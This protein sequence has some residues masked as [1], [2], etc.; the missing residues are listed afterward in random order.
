MGIGLITQQVILTTGE[1]SPY[2]NWRTGHRNSFIH[3]SEDCVCMLASSGLWE[4]LS[5]SS[6]YAYICEYRNIRMCPAS[7]H[8]AERT[9]PENILGQYGDS[10]YELI[11]G[12]QVTWT[13][14]EGTC[15]RNGG[16]LAHIRNV[17][18]QNYIVDFLKRHSSNLATW[19]G[20]TDSYSEGNF[21]WTS[22]EPVT[23]TNWMPGYNGTHHSAED[24]V[25]L[26][27]NNTGKWDE[28]YCGSHG[29]I[30]SSRTERHQQLCQ[31]TVSK[32]DYDCLCSTAVERKVYSAPSDTSS[33]V[34]YMY[35]FDCK[36]T[37]T[38]NAPV[39]GWV[40]VAF[41]HQVGY[42]KEDTETSVQ[43][44]N[45]DPPAADIVATA[46]AIIATDDVTTEMMT[47]E[48]ATFPT[49]T[50]P[51]TVPTTQQPTPDSTSTSA[52]IRTTASI[53]LST[54]IE[55][56]T[57]VNPVATTV[58]TAVQSCPLAVQ[59]EA[60]AN[61][62]L[63][64][65]NNVE[66][67]CYEFVQTKHTWSTSESNCNRNGGHLVTVRTENE[68]KELYEYVKAYGGSVWLGL[69]DKQNENNFTWVSG[70]ANSYTNWRPGHHNIF[71]HGSE[72][73]VC[74]LSISGQW[75]DLNC[76]SIYASIC[77][78][79]SVPDN[80][81]QGLGNPSLNSDGNIHMCPT[82]AIMDERLHPENILGQYG[83]SCY[84]LINGSRVT[85]AS[86]ESTCKRNGGHLAHIRNV[87]EQNYIIDFLKRHASNLAT[88]IGLS[89]S[90]SETHFEW[91]SGEPVTYTNWMPGYNGTHHSSEDCVVLLPNN[92]G[93]WDEVY[94][95]SHGGFFSTST[96]RHQQLC[97]YK[98]VTHSSSILIG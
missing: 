46:P 35:E 81:G 29:G 55:T 70:E 98:T 4:D 41:L 39:A 75:E 69:S 37:L 38:L 34:G 79:G 82:S 1:A 50:Q 51:T 9:H 23:Y 2:T 60:K 28:V 36:Q 58:T 91:T 48:P 56:A 71:I 16:H 62:S 66:N 89:D 5:C 13:L 3:G 88:W 7:I 11:N 19:I 53:S 87:D 8:L 65:V 67:K 22:G 63:L 42:V 57:P 18:E 85:W 80:S 76:G 96:E 84:E 21:K 17:D 54:I 47:T 64:I 73:C 32:A 26:L 74:M 94:C 27:P 14:A 33:E 61:N 31:Y 86:A 25:V 12:S 59:Q 83:D 90:H 40:E 72:D 30:F 78:Y 93:K 24:C 20:L 6:S 97:Q 77:E 43:L 68:N 10:C 45:G 92:T 52:P 95:G 49:T 44:C 15:K